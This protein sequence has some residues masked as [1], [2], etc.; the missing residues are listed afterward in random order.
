MRLLEFQASKILMRDLIRA[1]DRVFDMERVGGESRIYDVGDRKG[2]IF[3]LNNSLRG[4]GLV[5]SKGTT[6]VQSIAVWEKIDFDR[7]PDFIIDIPDDAF[8]DEVI[9]PIIGFI[10]KPREGLIEG[11]ILESTRNVTPDEFKKL[12][13]EYFGEKA[14][15][16]DLE[17]LKVIK[18]HFDVHIP[19]LI[20]H[21]HSLRVGANYWNLYDDMSDEAM[22]AAAGAKIGDPDPKDKNFK[23]AVELQ[24]LSNINDMA[25]QNRIVL[26]G[27]RPDGQVFRI[28]GVE[29]VCA[30]LERMLHKELEGDAGGSSMEEQYKK[31]E[32]KVRLVASGE[33]EF[34]KSLL[35]TGMPSAGKALALDT[36]L[37]T[38]NGW[39]TMGDV[40]VGDELFDENGEIC[41][42]TFVTPVQLD[43]TC[44]LV[45]FSDGSTVVA[46][47]DHRWQVTRLAARQGNGKPEILTTAEMA[48]KLRCGTKWNFRIKN[49]KPLQTTNKT[50]S[51]H[52]YVLGAWLGDGTASAPTITV[53][54]LD[55]KEMVEQL[56]LHEKVMCRETSRKGVH[57]LRFSPLMTG[58]TKVGNDF[59]N[60]LRKLGLLNN[61]HIP[62][63]YLRGSVEQR[64]ALVQGLMDTDGTVDRKGRCEFC[65]SDETL[66]TGVLELLRSLGI[67][68]QIKRGSTVKKDRFRISFT[69]TLNVFKLSRKVERL[70]NGVNKSSGYRSIV[71]CEIVP[72]VPVK[73]I[74]V[75]SPSHLFLCTENL[76]P[77]HN[78]FRV[79]KT[80]KELGLKDG[81]DYI[82]KKGKITAR[83]L[84]RVLIEQI[85]G[86]AIFD[87]CDS[88]V[89]DKSG[90]NMLKGALDTDPIR[91]VSYD[92]HG[93]LNTGAMPREK[94]N[95]IVTAM[96]RIL[97][98]V[99]TMAD[100]RLF[101]V[102][103]G[104][105][106]GETVA[107]KR[108][109][110]LWSFADEDE[111]ETEAPASTE[112]V[113]PVE[114]NE[115]QNWVM[116]NLPNKIDFQGRIIF[117]SNMR[118]DEWDGAILT[119]AFHQNMDFP[120][121]EMLDYIDSIKQHIHT[122]RLSESDKQEVIDYVRQLWETGKIT[123]PINFR[124]IQQAFDLF[125]MNDWRSLVASIG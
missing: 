53:G 103:R 72:S 40:Q 33:S 49:S 13:R 57:L 85:S 69:T 27:R 90:I 73:C 12:A 14:R 66:A 3:L 117:I 46:D 119:R 9:E 64:L 106:R 84:Y 82:V 52:P 21:D 70:A 110:K 38:P 76:I 75:D 104:K 29:E 118:E 124:L 32:Q 87:D 94:R 108:R 65:M 4:I 115:I 62:V 109:N 35:I 91:E 98:G 120:D 42:V 99:P 55:R 54:E 102:M 20:R 89:E 50:Y 19:S 81:E 26:M 123:K 59:K 111:D 48:P 16:L 113:D 25:S 95:E 34:V 24:K 60:R 47:A 28:P 58:D 2:I 86:L 31:L 37:P 68:A 17:D 97:R 7:A 41:R 10:K 122:P 116:K 5:W 100:V 93:L 114:L 107:A 80:I 101:D 56:S 8:L 105:S 71:S 36:K 63:E 83:S 125:L 1:L 6:A 43:R 96:S 121:I 30:K 79:M 23:R 77:T 78:T 88:V 51:V 15:K 45:T 18:N 44:Y 61:K 22:A 74:T 11:L 92:V 39:T 112:T 67:K